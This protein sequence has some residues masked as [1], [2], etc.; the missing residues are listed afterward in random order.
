VFLSILLF[1]AFPDIKVN[2][3]GIG[4]LPAGAVL[5]KVSYLSTLKA[6]IT[7]IPIVGSSGLT[8]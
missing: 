3:I 2:K 8:G 1:I 7:G 5:G 6:G 4:P